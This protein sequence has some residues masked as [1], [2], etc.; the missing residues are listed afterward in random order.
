MSFL[1]RG[2]TAGDAVV[3]LPRERMLVTGDLVV[4]PVPYM[5]SGFPSEYVRHAARD[6]TR[7]DSTCWCR[8]TVRC[9]AGTRAAVRRCARAASPRR[10]IAAVE[11]QVS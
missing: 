3:Y 2:N 6:W 4:H 1:G 10:V 9:C 5:F 8:A 7:L 11:Q